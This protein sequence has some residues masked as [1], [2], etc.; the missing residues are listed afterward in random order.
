MLSPTTR[1]SFVSENVSKTQFYDE[2]GNLDAS[3][4]GVSSSGEKKHMF[5]AVGLLGSFG[6]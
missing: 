2:P 6:C 5:K 3:K 4:I 1:V